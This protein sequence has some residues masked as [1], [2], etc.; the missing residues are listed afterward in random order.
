MLPVFFFVGK[1]TIQVEGTF[2]MFNKRAV[3]DILG[4]RVDQNV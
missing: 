4:G 3:I 2:K 1:W